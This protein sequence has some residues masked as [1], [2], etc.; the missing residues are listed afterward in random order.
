[1]L[2]QSKIRFGFI[3]FFSLLFLGTNLFAQTPHAKGLVFNA[4]A[5][6]KT[7]KLRDLDHRGTTMRELPMQLSFR[8]F[9]PTP[10]DQGAES[11]C[12]TWA[13]AYGALTMQQ[14][15]N[16]K[17]T[18][19]KDIDK[20]AHSKSFVF[21]QLVEKDRNYT[22][23]VEETFEFLQKNGTCLA[24]TFRNDIP[25]TTKP[26]ALAKEDAQINRLQD[27][28]EVFDPDVTISV[29][30]QIL[31]LKRLLADSHAVIVGLRLPFSFTNLKEKK[32]I[33]KPK[34]PIDSAA[35]ALCLIGY[36][37]MDST[38]ELMNSW[39]TNWGDKGF[40][41]LRYADMIGLMCCA[42]QLKFPT[43]RKETALKG[44]FVL[45]KNAGYS[46]Q[47]TPIFEEI[48]VEYD[49]LNHYYQTVQRTWSVGE[50]FQ[51]ALRQVPPNWWVNAFNI[52][53]QGDLSVFYSSN[54]TSNSVEK[55]LPSDDVKLAL[56]E[57]G[58]EW[59]GIV[60]TKD[61]LLTSSGS[62]ISNLQVFLQKMVQ[63][64]PSALPEQLTAFFKNQV[65]N[66]ALISPKR[67]GFSFPK[68]ET[69]N[70]AFLL[71]KIVAK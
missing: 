6:K 16:R 43:Y 7:V 58:I 66:N 31:R 68:N 64:K 62:A 12:T 57:E 42:Y 8:P 28:K 25:L 37:D 44:A 33:F 71:L 21:N 36:D 54:Q 46:V 18:N 48:R 63:S 32:F 27:A 52:N 26:D 55:T 39:G 9:C 13:V 10:Q 51:I 3:I 14:A 70:G 65:T 41:R 56:E 29:N 53:T 69:A 24:T 50:G 22:P 23:S 19:L 17:V 49:S 1:M 4:V 5:Y 47:K 67:M 20:I 59:L 2:R 61:P 38:F 11:S 40:V 45:R 35:H 34:E 30:K 15:M 60:C